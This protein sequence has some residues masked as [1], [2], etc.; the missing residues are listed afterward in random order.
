MSDK[1]VTFDETIIIHEF[2]EDDPVT[3]IKRG[4]IDTGFSYKKFINI[5]FMILC[6]MIII[7]ILLC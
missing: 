6:I 4:Y 5:L 1:R 3:E 7:L 2:N